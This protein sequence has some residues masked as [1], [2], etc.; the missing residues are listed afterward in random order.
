MKAD[1][2]GSKLVEVGVEH[3][4]A[5]RAVLDNGK[6]EALS[7]TIITLASENGYNDV[8]LLAS[9]AAV[10]FQ[11]GLGHCEGTEEALETIAKLKPH[12][13]AL[14]L[15]LAERGPWNGNELCMC[16]SMM[17]KI[18]V[19]ALVAFRNGARSTEGGEDGQVPAEQ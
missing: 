7:K 1:M 12:E 16:V 6:V 18:A 4:R 8:E 15:W 19:G 11:M 9:L 2:V 3:N 17:G 10:H 5:V 14:M 13:E